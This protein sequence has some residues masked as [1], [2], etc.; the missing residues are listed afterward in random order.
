M[1]AVK[2][3][4]FSKPYIITI[5]SGKGGVGKSF[6]TA[7]LA[8]LLAQSGC[9]TLIIDGDRHFPNQHLIT[10]AEPSY[11]L[12]DVI[13]GKIMPASALHIICDNLHLL[14]EM[15]A[16]LVDCHFSAEKYFDVFKDLIIETN[17]DVII[18]DTAS[19]ASEETLFFCDLSDVSIVIINDE[20]VSILDAY[21]LIKILTSFKSN[22]EIGLLVNNVIDAEDADEV[23]GKL[24]LALERFLEKSVDYIGFV[25]Y[26]RLVRQSIIRQELFV[27]NYPNNEISKAIMSI[28]SKFAEK[29]LDKEIAE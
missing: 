17:F 3:N 25:P 27:F 1:E 28:A 23:S 21:A 19:G 8:A 12:S 18:V 7:N 4:M 26:D 16:D 10:G 13:S 14:A 20:P 29:L 11:R 22:N 24:N 9:N 5:C 6:L 2:S 15:P